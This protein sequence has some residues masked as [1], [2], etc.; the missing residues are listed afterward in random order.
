MIRNSEAMLVEERKNMRGG[1]GS[2]QM[3]HLFS[4]EE[5]GRNARLSA[6]ITLPPGASIG[7]HIHEGER[8][9]FYIMSGEATLIENGEARTIRP[10]DA[11]LTGPN[12]EHSIINQGDDPVY[13]LAVII[14][15]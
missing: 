6:E 15:D 3:R 9:L 14:L 13:L 8:E 12:G 5:L 7:T 4:A 2:V 10:G 1:E 11:S